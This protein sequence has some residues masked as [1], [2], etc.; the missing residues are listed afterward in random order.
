VTG[1]TMLMG[2]E[3]KTATVF[4]PL[5]PVQALDVFTLFHILVFCRSVLS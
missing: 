1:L 5:W 4:C 3:P 2:N